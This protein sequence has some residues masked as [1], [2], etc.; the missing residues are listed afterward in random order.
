MGKLS[1][2]QELLNWIKNQSGL[3]LE[4]INY[5]CLP[6]VFFFL[7]QPRSLPAFSSG[8]P[9]TWW[10]SRRHRSGRRLTTSSWGSS[11]QETR[12]NWGRGFS[13]SPVQPDPLAIV[14]SVGETRT[15][16]MHPAVR[17]PCWRKTFIW[18]ATTTWK[19]RVLG[20]LTLRPHLEALGRRLNR[21]L[22][23]FVTATM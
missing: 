21:L 22:L 19:C 9:R 3:L 13:H 18:T 8:L 2:T 20:R 14:S 5:H 1:I 12:S 16:A 7:S 10:A 15:T 17:K 6:S 23:H 11:W 4:S